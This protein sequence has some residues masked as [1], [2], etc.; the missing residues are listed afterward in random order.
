MSSCV[1]IKIIMKFLSK[2]ETMLIMEYFINLIDENQ[3]E[4]LVVVGHLH[5]HVC[6][7]VECRRPA[8]CLRSDGYV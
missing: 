3:L 4:C 5:G 7:R 2:L 6:S 1:T 8:I